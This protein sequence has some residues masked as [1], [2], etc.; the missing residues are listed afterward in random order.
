MCACVHARVCRGG[1]GV[2]VGVRVCECWNG[3]R[4]PQL[5]SQGGT[6][7]P[8]SGDTGWWGLPFPWARPCHAAPEK[9]PLSSSPPWSASLHDEGGNRESPVPSAA[10]DSAVLESGAGSP[11]S[12]S[13]ALA[14]RRAPRTVA[15]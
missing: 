5:G 7:W 15:E 1:W 8:V 3:G 14:L 11:L 10:P 2:G 9:Q 12:T 6:V 13:R 4:R